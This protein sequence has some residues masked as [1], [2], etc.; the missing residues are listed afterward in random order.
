MPDDLLALLLDLMRLPGVPGSEA[1]VADKLH[2]AWSPLSDE[3]RRTPA[4]SVHAIR[5]GRGKK[6]HPSV[7]LMAHM[8]SVGLVVVELDGSFVRVASAG[9]IAAEHLPGQRVL[10]HGRRL[11]PGIAVQ[12]PDDC[13]P[14]DRP[15][16]S[17]PLGAFLVDTGLSP[18][19][20]QGQVRIGDAI[21][22]DR[23]PIHLG[24][25]L[26]SGPTLDNRVGLA[27]LTIALQSL[28]HSGHAWDVVSV[29]SVQE[30]LEALGARTSGHAVAPAVALVI[31]TTYGRSH[32]QAEHLTFPLGGGPSNGWGPAA[33]PAIHE[34]L[35]RAADRLEIP[36]SLEPMP[37][38]SESDADVLQLV[39]AGIPTGCLFIPVR[40]MHSPVEV[41]D[42]ED[43]RRTAAI[44]AEFV[45]ALD[46]IPGHSGKEAEP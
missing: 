24:N 27:A 40:Y 41:V 28:A 9:A 10:I 44:V 35:R 38:Y 4:G 11:I 8:D 1:A 12:P 5:H 25:G 20:L 19:Q 46:S 2:A 16:G 36:L 30:E 37:R 13:L 22:F 18:R 15:E 45:R 43:I 14:A 42:L 34:Q 26:V 3:I 21:T 33:H 31:D 23:M 6:P 39:G 7:L 17:V 29:G 32:G